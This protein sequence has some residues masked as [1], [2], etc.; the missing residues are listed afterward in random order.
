MKKAFRI[1]VTL[2]LLGGWAMAAAAVHLVRAPGT[3]EW[4]GRW[5]VVTK[6]HLTFR[7]TY[8]DTSKWSMADKQANA[9]LVNRFAESGRLD[10]V[11]H[12]QP[13]PPPPAPVVEADAMAQRPTA[14]APAEPTPKRNIFDETAAGKPN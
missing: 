6:D 8:V 5:S 11:Q 1:F 9:A 4:L 13:A 12:I 3:P 2:L 10:L 14:A 7:Q